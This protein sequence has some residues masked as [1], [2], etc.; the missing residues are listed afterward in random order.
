MT[1]LNESW[2][3]FANN[4]DLNCTYISTLNRNICYK[5]DKFVILFNESC[6]WNVWSPTRYANDNNQQ[7]TQNDN[8]SE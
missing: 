8:V 1:M 2:L 6:Y 3:D 4:L 5:L 7:P